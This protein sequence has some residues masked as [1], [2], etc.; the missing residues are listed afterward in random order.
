[1]SVTPAVTIEP[2]LMAATTPEDPT[3][4][5]TDDVDEGPVLTAMVTRITYTVELAKVN[6]FN[7]KKRPSRD[8]ETISETN[9]VPLK[10]FHV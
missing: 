9:E 5:T 1:M 4:T 8:T 6:G 7:L 3:C 10:T 2:P